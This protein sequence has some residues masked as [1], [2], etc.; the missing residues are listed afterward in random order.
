MPAE[1]KVASAYADFRIDVDE[2]IDKAKARIKQRQRD[3]DASAKI[4][5]DMDVRDAK[6]QIRSEF[7]DERFTVKADADTTLARAR[8]EKLTGEGTFK[9]KPDVDVPAS[10]RA[11]QA[12]DSTISRMANRANAKFDLLKFTVFTAGLPAAAA[13]GSALTVAA[14]ATVPIAFAGMA[15]GMLR[16]T[17][18]VSNAW[19]A[20]SSR[21]VTDAQTM[22]LSLQDEVVGA[23]DDMGAAWTRLKPKVQSAMLAGAPAIRE[24]TGAVTDLAEEAMP[25]LITASQKSGDA[26]HGFR[27]LA[28]QTGAG[29]SDMF[30]NMSSGSV[31]SGKDITILGG[32]VQTLL[33][34]IGQLA[35]NLS[36]AGEGPLRSFDVIV[37][38]LSGS[39]VDVTA[40]G[41]GTIGMLQGFSTTGSGLVTILHG[42]LAAAAAL[43]P[44]ITEIGG[45]IAATGM[46]ANKF[47]ID[48]TAGFDGFT[49]KVSEAKGA[50]GKFTAAWTGVA[51]GLFNPATVAVA[52]L[53]IGLNLL[54]ACLLYT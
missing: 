45:S 6:A 19:G 15:V 1:F 7:R 9:I 46:L 27:V 26:I 42:V 36:N 4:K 43:P 32:T 12:M 37:D 52:A 54:G 39:L 30:I 34:R 38:Q 10:R 8:L 14:L 33:G 23:V 50:S 29:L 3:L 5:L 24:L 18:Q 47:G 53:G 28:G 17:D 20:F 51:A 21:V 16:G 41:S 11:E 2:G 35:A 13:A 25:G 22:S 49:K 40:K 31:A 44:G 48:A